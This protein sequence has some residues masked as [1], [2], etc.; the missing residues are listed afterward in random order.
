MHNNDPCFA[1]A[2]SIVVEGPEQGLLEINSLEKGR[3]YASWWVNLPDKNNLC[4]CEN[5]FVVIYGVT[6]KDSRVG[7]TGYGGGQCNLMLKQSTDGSLI[8]LDKTFYAGSFVWIIPYF[9]EKYL[10]YRFPPVAEGRSKS[11]RSNPQQ[12]NNSE[13]PG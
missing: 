2:D 9:Y 11:D 3:P 1:L 5:G 10:W 12:N 13:P 4:R 7:I 6:E 8:V